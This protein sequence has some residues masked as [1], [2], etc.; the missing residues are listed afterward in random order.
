V[1]DLLLS[2]LC[3]VLIANLLQLYNRRGRGSVLPVFLGNYFL[4]ALFSFAVIPARAVPP[5]GFDLGLGL[6]A[7]LLFLGNF[8]IYQKNIAGNG[9]SLSV[10]VMRISVIVPVLV[11]LLVFRERLELLNGL[12]IGIALAAFML[13]SN[14]RDLH[15]WLW[16]VALFLVSGATETSLKL[17]KELGGGSEQVFIFIIFCS[18]FFITL[19]AI[20]AKRIPVSLAALLFGFAVGIPNRMSTVFFLQGLNTVPAVIA[21]PLVAIGVMLFSIV[22]DTLIWKRRLA[23]REL[24]MYAL[25]ALSVVLLNL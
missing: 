24:I 7:G 25:L 8:F 19:A 14:L 15:A 1:A 2:I 4:A 3:S 5:T 12:G 10:S 13:R 20:V 21:F 17:F 23:G 22:S 9:L 11:S 18:A 16:L 6:V